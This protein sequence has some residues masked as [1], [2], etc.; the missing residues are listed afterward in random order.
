M[1][2]SA[3][4]FAADRFCFKGEEFAVTLPTTVFDASTA[5]LRAA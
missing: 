3:R 1:F 4:A 5:P 2:V